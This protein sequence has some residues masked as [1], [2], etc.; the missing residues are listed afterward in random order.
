MKATTIRNPK[1]AMLAAAEL[2]YKHILNSVRNADNAF[3][4]LHVT[5]NKGRYIGRAGVIYNC[6]PSA[7]HGLIFLVYVYRKTG[8]EF[9]NTDGESRSYRPLSDFTLV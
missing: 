9:L 4:G 7:Q 5:I 8:G 3:K 6:I 2:S 1:E